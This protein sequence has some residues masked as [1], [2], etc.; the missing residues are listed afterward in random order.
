MVNANAVSSDTARGSY[1]ERVSLELVF[2]I[3]LVTY[4][5]PRIGQR[6]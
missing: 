2:L 1:P 3:Q 4:S 6:D 5:K